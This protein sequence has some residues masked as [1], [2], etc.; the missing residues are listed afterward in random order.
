MIDSFKNFERLRYRLSKDLRDVSDKIIKSSDDSKRQIAN[1]VFAT[2]FTACLSD[3]PVSIA[4][5]HNRWLLFG[6]KS[7]AFVA[8]YFISYFLYRYLALKLTEF[9]K[10]IGNRNKKQHPI[11]YDD[12]K[13]IIKE[14]DNIACDSIIVAKGYIS[15]FGL[16]KETKLQVFYFYE[17]MHC[18]SAASLKITV[19]LANY[20]EC[21]RTGSTAT[22]VD[23]FR[24]SNIL[25]I[26]RDI[27]AFLNSNFLKLF[28]NHKYQD[29]ITARLNDII[30]TIDCH[31]KKLQ[32]L[33][34]DS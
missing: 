17:I 12:S 34:E 11:T 7:I 14:F 18:L 22:G 20:G 31:E 15:E 1:T 27:I 9:S 4:P 8:I 28:T 32:E 3:V 2:I 5:T 21:I 23:I 16:V 29:D 6:I 33:R 25:E 30:T 26:E 24:L 10:T 19:L 13:Q